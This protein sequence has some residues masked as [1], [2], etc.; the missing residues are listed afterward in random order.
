[1]DS[2]SLRFCL[3]FTYGL[4]RPT[5]VTNNISKDLSPKAIATKQKYYK[6][7]QLNLINKVLAEW[8]RLR[9]NKTDVRG[10]KR[11]TTTMARDIFITNLDIPK[12]SYLPNRREIF[13]GKGG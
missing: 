13:A 7:K 9:E 5:K 3:Q 1:M 8:W 11:S 10:N 4:Y 12:T 6:T 2:K